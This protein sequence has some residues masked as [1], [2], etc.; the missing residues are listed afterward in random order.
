MILPNGHYFQSYTVDPPRV[1]WSALELMYMCCSSTTRKLQF[2]K[3]PTGWA[4][5][6]FVT[7]SGKEIANS[8]PIFRSL[9][10]SGSDIFRVNVYLRYGRSPTILGRCWRKR[11]GDKAGGGDA[12]P[13]DTCTQT[14]KQ[15]IDNEL[16]PRLILSSL[17]TAL[18]DP[19]TSGME[20]TLYHGTKLSSKF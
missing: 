16:Y 5:C 4:L 10:G 14:W 11:G 17:C 7:E 2:S 1:K 6:C 9:D 3:L 20:Q 18:L 19:S 15:A 13:L 12:E 8:S